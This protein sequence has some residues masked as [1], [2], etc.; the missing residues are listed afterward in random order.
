MMRLDARRLTGSARGQA[1]TETVL[2]MWGLVLLLAIMIQVF[3]IDQHAYR[4]A[5]RAHARL[6]LN[7]AYP[8]NNPGVAYSAESGQ[9]LQGRDEYVPVIGYFRAYGLTREDL[10]IRSTQARQDGRK[11]IHIGAGTKAD[12]FGALQGFGDPAPLLSQIETG[13][14]Q[15]EE[16]RRRAQEAQAR[17]TGAGR[18]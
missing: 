10:R 11:E 14:G 12:V 1:I 6:F 3:L 16:A 15:I 9:K 17:A 8:N 4:L 13:L 2:M 5:T 18:R 7:V